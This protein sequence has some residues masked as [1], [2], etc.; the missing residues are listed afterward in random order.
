LL[1]AASASRGRLLVLVRPTRV[2]SG[3]VEDRAIDRFLEP[4]SAGDGREYHAGV[5]AI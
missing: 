5:A 2:P 3:A 1:N 4:V